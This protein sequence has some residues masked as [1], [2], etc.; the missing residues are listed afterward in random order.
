VQRQ[1]RVHAVENAAFLDQHLRTP[2]GRF[3]RGLQDEFHRALEP[4]LPLRQQLGGPERAG[5]VDVVSAR[6]HDA[7]RARGIVGAGRFHDGKGIHVGTDDERAAGA[8]RIERRQEAR[9]ARN[10]GLHLKPLALQVA[11]SRVGRARLVK[12]QLRVAVNVAAQLHQ[13]PPQ[14][15]GPA[16]QRIV[17]HGRSKKRRVSPS[18]ARI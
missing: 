10:A 14:F 11:P 15:A 13:F 1:R 5:H 8:A 16:H 6:V 18:P 9:R 3:L 12:R 17:R 7:L 4:F 2:R